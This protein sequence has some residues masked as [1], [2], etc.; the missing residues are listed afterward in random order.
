MA[1]RVPTR[2]GRKR[3]RLADLNDAERTLDHALVNVRRGEDL[4]E[5]ASTRAIRFVGGVVEKALMRARR[6]VRSE[7]KRER[8]RPH[9]RQT[10]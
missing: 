3:G 4:V 10:A 9:R 7:I 1:L 8:S 5:K 2:T 6:Q